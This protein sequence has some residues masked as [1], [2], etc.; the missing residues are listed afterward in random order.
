[1]L[2]DRDVALALLKT[3]GLDAAGRERIRR[4]AQAMGRLGSHPHIVTVLDLGESPDGQPFLITELMAG[5]DIERLIARAPDHPLPLAQTLPVGQAVC[6]APAFAHEHGIG[7]R[8]VKPGN[9][10]LSHRIRDTPLSRR[11][12]RKC[13]CRDGASC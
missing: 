6:R 8:D 11:S 7:H 9:V 12:S 3:A 10:W 13:R 1:M 2:L 5:G 4:E